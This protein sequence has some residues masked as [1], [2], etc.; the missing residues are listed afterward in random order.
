MNITA[1]EVKTK[2]VSVFADALK[3]ADEVVI[4]VRGKNK[5]V[6]LDIDRYNHFRANELDILYIQAMQDIKN[7]DYKTQ[8]A[9]QHIQYVNDLLE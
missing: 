6:V 8:T 7:G 9:E 5:Y 4:N 2:G 1:N 3:Q